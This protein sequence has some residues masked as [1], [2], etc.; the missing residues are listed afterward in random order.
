[1]ALGDMGSWGAE[2]EGTGGSPSGV[3]NVLLQVEKNI[4]E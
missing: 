2:W 4:L 3:G 1:M